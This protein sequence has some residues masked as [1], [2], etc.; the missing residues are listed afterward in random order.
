VF[1]TNPLDT[2]ARGVPASAS[3]EGTLFR[4]VS[5]FLNG[6]ALSV[7]NGNASITGCTFRGCSAGLVRNAPH[8]ETLAE[9]RSSGGSDCCLHDTRLACCRPPSR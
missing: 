9:A 6:G 3:I 1:V 7:L 4:N 2:R 5:T 8:E